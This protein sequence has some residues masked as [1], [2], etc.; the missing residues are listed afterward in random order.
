VL[1][2]LIGHMPSIDGSGDFTGTLA[3]SSLIAAQASAKF[4]RVMTKIHPGN[5]NTQDSLVVTCGVCSTSRSGRGQDR[6]PQ[7]RAMGGPTTQL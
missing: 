2:E 1:A 5:G 6:A 3:P 4:K 7:P